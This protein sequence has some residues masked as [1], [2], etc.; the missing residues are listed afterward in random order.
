VL[1]RRP[2]HRYER[3]SGD[4]MVGFMGMEIGG[5]G[6]AE[7]RRRGRTRSIRRPVGAVNS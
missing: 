4:R 6:G 7:A 3:T 5:G 1:H 2:S